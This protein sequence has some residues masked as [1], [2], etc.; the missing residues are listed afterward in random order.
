GLFD[1]VVVG[2]G[3]GSRLEEI[4]RGSVSRQLL[5]HSRLIPVWIVEGAPRGAGIL[6]AVEGSESSLRAVDHLAF[7]L[8]GAA[9]PRIVL[10]HV[11]PRLRDVC[12][13]D[14]SAE[15]AEDLE[16]VVARGDRR[17]MEHFFPAAMRRLAAAGLSGA[18]ETATATVWRDV[19]PTILKEARRRDCGT[20]VLGRSGSGGSV[21]GGRVPHGV[22]RGLEDAALW[23]VP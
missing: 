5:E 2:R 18:V 4:F 8:A 7:M 12:E 15:A 20:I 17:C 11:A 22:L 1:A 19:A 13:I 9:S 21:L 6:A 16:E 23:V 14:F 3:G 10:F